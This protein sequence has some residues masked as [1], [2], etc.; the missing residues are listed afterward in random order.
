MTIADPS[1][2][3]VT[4]VSVRSRNGTANKITAHTAITTK[5]RRAWI[6]AAPPTIPKVQVRKAK[7]IPTV[8]KALVQI[9]A[10]VLSIRSSP[11]VLR[12]QGQITARMAIRDQERHPAHRVALPPTGPAPDKVRIRRMSSQE[13]MEVKAPAPTI[14]AHR[15]KV[16]LL[17]DPMV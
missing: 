10:L 9:K 4:W 7:D 8:P 14:R 13:L 11:A 2:S 16:R 3:P 1:M 5:A 12:V 15:R 6:I 17:A